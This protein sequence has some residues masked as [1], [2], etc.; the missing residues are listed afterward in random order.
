MHCAHPDS[1]D[2]KMPQVMEPGE[3]LDAAS[4]KAAQ[5]WYE[6]QV[7]QPKVSSKAKLPMR[8]NVV[9]LHQAFMSTTPVT[10]ASATELAVL[11]RSLPIRRLTLPVSAASASGAPYPRRRG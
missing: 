2:E 10:N 9:Q 11:T 1:A 7:R 6:P 3:V 8:S 5:G 4:E